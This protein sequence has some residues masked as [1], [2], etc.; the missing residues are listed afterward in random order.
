VGDGLVLRSS[1][2]KPACADESN[3]RICLVTKK[4]ESNVLFFSN[5]AEDPQASMRAIAA[6]F[7]YETF[8]VTQAF[9]AEA[10]FSTCKRKIV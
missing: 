6:F 2:S 7:E 8:E 5:V 3:D 4:N 10:L 1:S 9:R